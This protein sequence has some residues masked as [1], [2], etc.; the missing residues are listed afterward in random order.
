MPDEL[1]QDDLIEVKSLRKHRDKS[2]A[3]SQHSKSFADFPIKKDL[4]MSRA[5]IQKETVG[6]LGTIN[7]QN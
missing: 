2:A 5:S 1:L 4:Q 7:E 3:E 6:K